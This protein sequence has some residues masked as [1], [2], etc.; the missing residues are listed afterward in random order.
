VTIATDNQATILAL[1]NRKQQPGSYL[2]NE[3]NKMMGKIK[4][5]WPTVDITLRWIPGHEG[6]EGNEKA[7]EEAKEATKGRHKNKGAEFGILGK[8]LPASKSAVLRKFKEKAK[9]KYQQSFRGKPRYERMSKFEP[10]APSSEFRNASKTLKRA[11]VSIMTQ[12]RTGHVPL[13]SYLHRFKLEESPICPSCRKEPETV[14]H[15]LK[16]CES[17]K[18]ARREMR[19]ELGR[20]VEV[21]LELLGGKKHIRTIL[22]YVKRTGRFEET[23][24]I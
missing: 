6:L 1:N 22:R 9:T 12:L 2:H 20:D 8:G 18:E 7:D 19:R 17:H 23:H 16:F 5:K 10:K 11:E 4:R 13:Q 14:T 21:G 24:K 15:Y 3:A